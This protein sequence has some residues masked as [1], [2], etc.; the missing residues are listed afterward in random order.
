MTDGFDPLFLPDRMYPSV[1]RI[2]NGLGDASSGTGGFG[3][4]PATVGVNQEM[5][6]TTFKSELFDQ[7]GASYDGPYGNNDGIDAL[8]NQSFILNTCQSG[9]NVPPILNSSQACDTLSVCRR[10]Y[11][12]AWR[13]LPFS[14]TRT[15]YHS[16]Y[17]FDNDRVTVTSLPGNTSNFL[18]R[19]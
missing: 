11:Y 10:R 8:D 15:N 1:T 14:G 13:I 6:L 19:L 7:A 3:G 17:F 18:F 9:S 5:V 2:C 16:Y 12:F 4:T